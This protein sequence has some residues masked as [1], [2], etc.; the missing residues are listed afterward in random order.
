MTDFNFKKLLKEKMKISAF[1]YLKV[2]QNK[3]E[4]IKKI[5]YEKLEMQEYLAE[6]DR[7][8]NVSK[9]IFKARGMTL[10]IKMHKKWKYEDTLCT[11]CNVSEESGQELL[12]CKGFGEVNQNVSYD[13]FFSEEIEDQLSVGKIMTRKLKERKRLREEVT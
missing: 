1:E 5:K 9:I 8:N 12:H 13:M 4:K 11:G 2:Q 10:D 6:G 3:Q 7:N